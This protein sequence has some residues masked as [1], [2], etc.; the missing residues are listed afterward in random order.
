MRK[1]N[2]QFITTFVS[3]AG[4]DGQNGTYY[5]FVEMDGYYCMAVAEG[6]DGDGGLESAKLAVDTAIEAFVQKPSMKA[7][8]IRACLKKAHRCLKEH[9]V[10]IRLK[11]GIL[12][13][14]SDYT[15]FRY[16]VCGNVMLYAF[17]NA[18][19]YHQS[20][21]HTVYQVMAD[22]QTMSGEGVGP[23][24]ETANLYHYL[25]GSGGATVSG[26]IRL[27]DGDMVL[28]VTEG[29]WNRVNRVE[30]LD[31]YESIQSV[32]E[33]LGDLQELYLRGSMDSIP[34]CCLA[35]IEIKKAY[36]ENTA[37]KKKIWIWCLVILMILAIGGTAIAFFIRAKR[38]RQNEIRSTT[39]I[40]EDTGDQYMAG[41]NSLLAKQEYEKAAE[42]NRK[43][44]KNEE[45][46]AKERL[47]SDKI[48]ISVM[49]D[50]AGKSYAAKNFTQARDEYKNALEM[51]EKYEELVPLTQ[52][53][54]QKMKLVSTG[55]EIANYMESA[56]LKEAAGDMETAGILYKR[57]EAMLRIVDDA[58]RLKEV[59]LALLRVKEQADEE[60]RQERA[61]ARDEVI[62][63]ADKTEALNA[64]LAGDFEAALEQYTKIRDSYIAM[65]ENEK[66]EET[67]QIILSLQKQA[68]EIAELTSETIDSDKSAAMDAL[69]AGDTE[70]AL[71]LYENMLEA[72]LELGDEAG[73]EETKAMIESLQKQMEAAPAEEKQESL[74][75]TKQ[76]KEPEAPKEAEDG[77]N[78]VGSGKSSADSGP[79]VQPRWTGVD[80]DGQALLDQYLEEALYATARQDFE[81]AI[82]A[83]QEIEK[84]Y[85]QYGNSDTAI[86][87][88]VMIEGLKRLMEESQ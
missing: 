70:T 43:L 21:T 65:E 72:Y 5:G 74:E 49:T 10:R 52:A 83:Y 33:F 40:Y 22:R 4:L 86:K 46:L 37:L 67:T 25:G 62:I 47:L 69:V 77:K 61:K 8:R 11:A 59:Q 76:A 6:Y 54:G 32:E 78:A 18:G 3:E 75:E 42:E 7:G 24:E 60:A 87:T 48:N 2:S 26:K 55:M 64:V 23:K 53:I 51:A 36:K 58:E 50:Q 85:V 80:G 28:A 30:L 38:R 19:I 71:M 12:L 15:R 34:C 57:A 84:L 82:K 41:L 27:Q 79:G 66:A 16:G 81:A 14:V 56:A 29:F 17:R 9:S 44:D 13:M 73:A 35:A 1:L 63:D 45:R 31:A 68:R 20:A 88:D 39:S